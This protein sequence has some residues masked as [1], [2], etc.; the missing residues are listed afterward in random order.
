MCVCVRE[1]EIREECKLFRCQGYIRAIGEI[2]SSIAVRWLELAVLAWFI[3]HS[4][5]L[6]WHC[7]IG[8]NNFHWPNIDKCSLIYLCSIGQEALL[9][10]YL[11]TSQV[12]HTFP[13][14]TDLPRGTPGSELYVRL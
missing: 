2:L 13:K 4:E 5:S 14:K 1:R 11:L 6:T 9:T 3:L 7:R 12:L 10:C 8:S